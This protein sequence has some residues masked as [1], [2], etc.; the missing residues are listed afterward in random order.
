MRLSDWDITNPN[1]IFINPNV[2][3]V[4][5]EA[6][7]GGA[8][9]S[10]I[11]QS[12]FRLDRS[13]NTIEIQTRGSKKIISKIKQAQDFKDLWANPYAAPFSLCISS[14]PSEVMA[15]MVAMRLFLRAI[16]MTRKRHLEGLPKWHSVLGGWSDD[17]LRD[18]PM[19]YN[20]NFLV[21]GNVEENSTPTKIEK[22]RDI[23][24]RYSNVPKVIVTANGSPVDFMH[25]ILK[26]PV[27]YAIYLG[28][29]KKKPVQTF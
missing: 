20:I 15:Q 7:G 3:D 25:D 11:Q 18:G 22:L 17:A 2:S 6:L 9:Q 1:H 10:L 4:L 21:L 12:P 5:Y 24:T 8:A 19:D 28:P 29:I 16:A 23:V 27:H 26:M 13:V 14:A